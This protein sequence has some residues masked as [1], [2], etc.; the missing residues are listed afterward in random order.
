MARLWPLLALVLILV[1]CAVRLLLFEREASALELRL[2]HS[3]GGETRAEVVLL[4]SLFRLIPRALARV[5]HLSGAALG[6][7]ALASSVGTEESVLVGV[8]C[9][10]FGSTAALGISAWGKRIER[11]IRG[12]QR[13]FGKEMRAR[14][15]KV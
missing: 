6:F 10:V 13:S 4:G 7:T 12:L 8:G 15:G 2:A 5:A 11:R 1:G 3:P 9:L 14:E